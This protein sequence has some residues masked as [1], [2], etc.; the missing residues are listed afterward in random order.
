MEEEEGGG[1]EAGHGGDD[2]D[3]VVGA[4]EELDGAVEAGE[5]DFLHGGVV[6]IAFEI[7]VEGCAADAD[8]GGDLG[9][10]E[11]GVGFFVEGGADEI[12][13]AD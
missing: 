6:E 4:G 2:V 8:G 11:L 10:S 12:E 1:G 9:G 3:G 13:G 7:F 5:I